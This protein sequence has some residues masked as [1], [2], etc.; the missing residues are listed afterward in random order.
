MMF[1]N[2]IRGG[3][4]DEGGALH[5]EESSLLSS[6]LIV[7]DTYRHVQRHLL[8]IASRMACLPC[9]RLCV[10]M[11]IELDFKFMCFVIQVTYTAMCI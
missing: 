2:D 9:T 4:Q 3:V 11:K 10:L 7:T 6:Y 8:V 1:H 5:S